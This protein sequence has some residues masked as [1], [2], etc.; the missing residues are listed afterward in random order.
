MK[1]S[2]I[3]YIDSVFFLN[4]LIQITAETEFDNQPDTTSTTP[5]V[6]QDTDNNEK[7]IGKNEEVTIIDSI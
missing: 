1:L 4:Q 6:D 5:T 7:G 2:I 3:R